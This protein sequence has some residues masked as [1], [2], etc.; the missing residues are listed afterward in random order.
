VIYLRHAEPHVP[1]PFRV[2]N[3]PWLPLG[4]ILACLALM[5]GLT[6]LTWVRLTIWLVLGLVFYFAYG[7]VHSRLIGK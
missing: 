4:G 5:I 2:P 6:P 1:R 3:V 7:R